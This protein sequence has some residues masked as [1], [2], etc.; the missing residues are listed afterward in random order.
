[1]DGH[2]GEDVADAIVALLTNPA[3]HNVFYGRSFEELFA[4]IDRKAV[5]MAP[6]GGST[7]TLVGVDG[8][9]TITCANVGD[10]RAVL[11]TV[12]SDGRIAC[13]TLS[14]DHRP[15]D[16]SEFERIAA[17]GGMVANG[18]IVANFESIAVSRA[19]GDLNMD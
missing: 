8:E 14:G 12:Q 5:E 16:E 6:L 17:V 13:E 1:M 7:L 9:S 11:V 4:T 19:I 10:S 3:R 2:G 15:D 18:C